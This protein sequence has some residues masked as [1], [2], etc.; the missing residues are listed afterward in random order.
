MKIIILCDKPPEP[1]MD[2]L[3]AYCIQSGCVSIQCS[4]KSFLKKLK[5]IFN[6][7]AIIVY[8]HEPFNSKIE[9]KLIDYCID[10]GKL[11]AL[12]HSVA[13]AKLK[14][15]YW[16]DFMGA[17]IEKDKNSSRSWRVLHDV[18]I[19]VVN[20]LPSSKIMTN[21]VCYDSDVSF[22]D[23]A[24]LLKESL[25]PAF[26][27]GRSE[28]FINQILDDRVER[29]LLFG[30]RYL[31]PWRGV[32]VPLKNAG[33]FLKRGSGSIFYLMGGHKRSDFENENYC[34]IILNCIVF[35]SGGL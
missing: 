18:L 9:K 24:D 35:G 2:L 16:L 26:E 13:S 27:L 22:P 19:E 14:N 31:D 17:S 11:I 25:R 4:Q 28:V 1:Q 7:D 8:V 6:P 3:S 34:Q 23:L 32:M 30:F 5:K 33:W 20:L 15:K 29:T 12:H 21:R 10:G